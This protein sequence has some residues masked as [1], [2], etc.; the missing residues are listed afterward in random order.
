MKGGRGGPRGIKERKGK[1]R[2]RKGKRKESKSG[3]KRTWIWS[4]GL[5]D[6]T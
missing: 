5:V 2:K 1:E 4:I 6:W 3:L